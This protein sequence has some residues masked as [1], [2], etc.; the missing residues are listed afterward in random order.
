MGE[1]DLTNRAVVKWL[2][3]MTLQKRTTVNLK[4]QEKA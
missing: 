3:R 2:N 4:I 1:D